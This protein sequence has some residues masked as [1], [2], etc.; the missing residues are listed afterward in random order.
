MA[1]STEV[2]AFERV[3]SRCLGHKFDLCRVPLHERDAVVVRREDQSRRAPSIGTVSVRIDLKPWSLSSAVN[4]NRALVPCFTRMG[5][6]LNTYFLAVTSMTCTCSSWSAR[7]A[8][9]GQKTFTARAAP[10]SRKNE[11]VRITAMQ[12]DCSIK[13][14]ILI[15]RSTPMC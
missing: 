10:T 9:V 5:D 3:G 15:F 2:T 12:F 4:L 8:I 11:R 1:Q 13:T 6:G 7:E 14:R